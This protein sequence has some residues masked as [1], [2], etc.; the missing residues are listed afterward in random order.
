MMARRLHLAAST[1]VAI[2]AVVVLAPVAHAQGTFFSSSP[3]PLSESHASIDG[4]DHCNDCHNDSREVFND[5][6]LGCHDHAN[7]KKRIDAGQGFHAS[8]DARG[9]KC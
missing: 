2:A 7:L 1:I 3:G 5:R 9:K 4:P 8:A 6:C